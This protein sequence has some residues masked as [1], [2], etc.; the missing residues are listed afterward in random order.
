MMGK[1]KRGPL[2]KERRGLMGKGKHNWKRKG[3]VERKRKKRTHELLLILCTLTFI[4][5]V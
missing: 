5:L 4:C 1:E 2:G 3:I